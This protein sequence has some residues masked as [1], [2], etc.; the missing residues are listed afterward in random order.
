MSLFFGGYGNIGRQ[1]KDDMMNTGS[2]LKGLLGRIASDSSDNPAWMTDDK[3]LFQ[4]GKYGRTF[5]RIK[6][7]LGIEP[8]QAYD[9]GPE[10]AAKNKAIYDK[11]HEDNPDYEWDWDDENLEYEDDSIGGDPN[12]FV[13]DDSVVDPDNV[14]PGQ[15]R[16]A[17]LGNVVKGQLNYGDPN[18]PFAFTGS[19]PN[20]SWGG[21]KNW[22]EGYDPSDISNW[23]PTL[24]GDKDEEVKNYLKGLRGDGAPGAAPG[25]EVDG[26]TDLNFDNNFSFGNNL[27]FSNIPG[28]VQSG[29]WNFTNSLLGPFAN[30]NPSQVDNDLIQDDLSGQSWNTSS[31]GQNW[32]KGY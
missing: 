12:A 9:V 4:G 16:F 27:D 5:G 3:G 14:L 11:W 6:D 19:T 32:R 24:L 7:F 29:V 10:E 23:S 31:R 18:S 17:R 8:T 13:S 21:G 28:D 20:L 30:I 22:M 15:N 1:F 2:Q 25:I 26:G